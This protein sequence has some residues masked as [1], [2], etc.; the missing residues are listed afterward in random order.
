MGRPYTKQRERC[1]PSLATFGTHINFLHIKMKL[2]SIW[3]TK[4]KAGC[5]F[6]PAI[7]RTLKLRAIAN[8]SNK[9]FLIKQS[10]GCLSLSCNI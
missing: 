9:Y 1:L 8:L 4:K 5:L 7:F 10:A 3:H 6:S 2:L